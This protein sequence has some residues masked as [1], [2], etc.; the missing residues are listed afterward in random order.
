MAESF[1]ELLR[2]ARRDR[3]LTQQQLADFATVSVRTVRDLETGRC[4][5]PRPGTVRLLARQL[6]LSGAERERFEELAHRGSARPAQRPGPPPAGPG[7]GLAA[8]IAGLWHR[9][10]DPVLW[11]SPDGKLPALSDPTRTLLVIDGGD[12]AARPEDVVRLLR[13]CPGLRVV[14]T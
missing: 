5:A 11:L 1:G 4:R 7:R 6:G 14:T 12:P 3:G 8:Q 10:G 2:A 13:T 9:S